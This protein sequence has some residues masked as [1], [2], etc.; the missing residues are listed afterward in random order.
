MILPGRFFPP[1]R[2]LIVLAGDALAV[3]SS[4]PLSVSETWERVREARGEHAASLTFDWFALAL[5]LL[6]GMGVV[7]LRDGMVVVGLEGA[8]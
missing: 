1:E 3:L 4:G 8:K 6:H 2:A 7:S 5:A